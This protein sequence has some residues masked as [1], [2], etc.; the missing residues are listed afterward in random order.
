MAR[1]D[2]ALMQPLRFYRD[3]YD[4]LAIRISADLRYSGLMT[5]N[6]LNPSRPAR[7]HPASFLGLSVALR[8][9][10]S[11]TITQISQFRRV[12]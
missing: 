9:T 2:A 6:P 7:G 3:I 11:V 4:G 10:D 1:H 5:K 8:T 12:F